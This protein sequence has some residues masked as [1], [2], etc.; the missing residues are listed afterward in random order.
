LDTG[1]PVSSGEYLLIGRT[2]D[3][4]LAQLAE[5]GFEGITPELRENI[6]NFYAQMKAPTSTGSAH[7]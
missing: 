3:Q 1:R 7:N 2:Y 6:L 5:K 4:L